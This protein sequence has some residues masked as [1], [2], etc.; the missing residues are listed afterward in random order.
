MKV[1]VGCIIVSAL[2]LGACANNSSPRVNFSQIGPA[3]ASK[4]ESEKVEVYFTQKPDQ[5]YREIGILSVLTW[6]YQPDDVFYVS[7][8]KKKARE[9]GGDALIMLESQSEIA[10]NYATKQ[11]YQGKTYRAMAI[12][13][14]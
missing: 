12:A 1:L 2:L 9:V 10:T 6:E 5:P 7:A 8:L 14:E 4:Q 3:G 11:N 13:F